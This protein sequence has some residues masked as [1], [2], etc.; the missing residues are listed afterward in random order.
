MSKRVQGPR[1]QG[2]KTQ[3]QRP[4]AQ[5]PGQLANGPGPEGRGE[6]ES[7]VALHVFT[8]GPWAQLC[9]RASPSSPARSR[10]P[11]SE[12]KPP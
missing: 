1:A 12:G 3:D 10:S 6:A 4:E 5:G 11:R 9:P 8:W 7:P 2:P